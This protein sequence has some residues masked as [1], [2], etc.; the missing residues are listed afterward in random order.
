MR[1]ERRYVTPL[2]AA[3]LKGQRSRPCGGS[4]ACNPW[5]CPDDV[6]VDFHAT[7]GCAFSPTGLQRTVEVQQELRR[8]GWKPQF[9]V[10][11]DHKFY[12]ELILDDQEYKDHLPHSIDAVFFL[13]TACDDVFDGPKCEAYA[14]GAHR[15][16]LRHFEL[17][18]EQL[19]LVR[20]DYNN[21]ERPFEA[22]PNCNAAAVGVHSCGPVANAALGRRRP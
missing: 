2:V 1:R 13:P 14:R 10:W 21:W 5:R 8:R 11:D 12:N 18:E 6:D 9:K 4:G 22:A 20:F 17:T 3:P 15:N 7:T 19:P 16:L